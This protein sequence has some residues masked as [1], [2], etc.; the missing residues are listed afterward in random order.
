MRNCLSV[1]R[2]SSITKCI[3]FLSQ[4]N[5]QKA[6]LPY[7]DIKRE[8][9][10]SLLNTTFSSSLRKAS[11]HSSN[12]LVQSRRLS[13][14]LLP[15]SLASVI[16]GYAQAWLW[17]ILYILIPNWW[18]IL[19]YEKIRLSKYKMKFTRAQLNKQSVSNMG[20][21]SVKGFPEPVCKKTEGK[22]LTTQRV[23]QGLYW[24]ASFV[25]QRSQCRQHKSFLAAKSLVLEISHLTLWIHSPSFHTWPEWILLTHSL[26]LW[27]PFWP[28]QW[29][30]IIKLYSN[31]PICV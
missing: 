26:S 29:E 13:P 10:V 21:M 16:W 25:G 7:P 19:K 3:I 9:D 5:F 28:S 31:C 15:P 6:E 22:D 23:E 2:P 17:F 4:S 14:L 30:P 8:T 1:R 27:L 20:K 12:S 24:H 18:V 11:L